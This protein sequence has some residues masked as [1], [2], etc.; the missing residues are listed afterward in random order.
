MA[1]YKILLVKKMEDLVMTDVQFV[2]NSGKSTTV[3]ISHFQP[4]N[5]A[6]VMQ[7]IANRFLSERKK[8]QAEVA[9]DTVL[10]DLAAEVG[11]ET[12]I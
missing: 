8:S 7:G 4:A 12:T 3:S 1:T 9:N 2:F 6:D 5:R 11:V 10:S